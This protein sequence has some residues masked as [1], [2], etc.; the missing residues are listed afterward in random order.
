[1][2]RMLLAGFV[3]LMFLAVGCGQNANTTFS[4]IGMSVGDAPG[5]PAAKEAGGKPPAGDA[6][7]K[8]A[9]APADR[10]IIYT[11]TLDLVV[12]N[13]D[14][15]L[16]Q[17]EKLVA[18]QKG[19]IAKSEVK[20]DTGKRRTA[21]F[22][23]RVP[24]DSFQTAREGLLS[25]GTVERN[26][27]D[28]Q[29][30]TEEFVDV[31]ARIKNLKEQ[32]DKLNELLKEKRKEEKLEDIIK[33]SDRIA[34]VRRDVERVQGRLNYLA[35]MTALATINLTMREV[36]DYKPPTAPTFANRIN[37]TFEQSWEAV[38]TFGEGL[39]LFVVGFTAW[40][41]VLVPLG[42][43]IYLVRRAVRRSPKPSPQTTPRNPAA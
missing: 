15:V 12:T 1:M 27:V 33:V 19:Y 17:V 30:V 20:E 24:V 2:H 21:T 43:V 5:A 13:M 34:E 32:E 37:S 25:L 31:Q 11:G 9:T 18:A 29:D 22:S 26:A 41:V 38:V 3:G 4:K 14:E 8:G 7:I 36:K 28:S 23:L 35:N 40:L 39:V 16:P 42:I 10:K 6:A